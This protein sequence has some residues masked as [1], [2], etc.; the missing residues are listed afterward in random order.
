MSILN[1]FRLHRR[2]QLGLPDPRGPLS[3]S[4]TPSAI[5]SANKEVETLLKATSGSS[6]STGTGKRGEYNRYT[7]LCH[8]QSI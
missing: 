8:S 5:A 4:L 2:D 7:I 1:Y 3:T 6:C